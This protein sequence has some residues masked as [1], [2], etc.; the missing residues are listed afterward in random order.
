[1][2]ERISYH[3]H[4]ETNLKYD[5]GQK[6]RIGDLVKLSS[7]A[8]PAF[9]KSGIPDNTFLLVDIFVI[10]ASSFD[11]NHAYYAYIYYNGN[12]VLANMEEIYKIN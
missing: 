2:T 4:L 11:D 3:S 5:N 8:N 9:W 7:K 6:I 10:D 1:M 12:T